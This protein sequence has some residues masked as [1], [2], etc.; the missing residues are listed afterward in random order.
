[1][2]GAAGAAGFDDRQ[3]DGGG[4]ARRGVARDLNLHG[5]ARLFRGLRRQYMLPPV[6]AEG[7]RAK[8]AVGG[9][10]KSPRNDGHAGRV[11]PCSA[12]PWTMP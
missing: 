10:V 5:L 12:H 9:G 7:Q 3:H 4:N 6:R 2:P 11:M 8:R 1:M